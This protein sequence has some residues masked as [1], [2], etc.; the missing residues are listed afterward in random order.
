MPTASRYQPSA[1]LMSVILGVVGAIGSTT[2]VQAASFTPLPFGTYAD[3]QDSLG[4]LLQYLQISGDGTTVIGNRSLDLGIN[5]VEAFRWRQAESLQS[6]GGKQN[7]ALGISYDGSTIAGGNNRQ[8]FRWTEPNGI[9][10]L[11]YLPGLSESSIALAVSADGLTI[12]GNS[13]G[14]FSGPRSGQA[15]RWTPS[16]GMQGLGYLTNSTALPGFT[17]F[18]SSRANDVSGNGSVIV[19]TSNF[20]GSYDEAFRWTAAGGMQGL[21]FLPGG[22]SSFGNAVSQDGQTIVGSGSVGSGFP[23]INA[24]AFRWTATNG[25]Q[26]LDNLGYFGG[27]IAVRIGF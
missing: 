8:A 22:N 25:I 20:Y 1:L 21:G 16:N 13:S 14:A 19:G 11:G 27:G 17:D 24:K 26:D 3:A 2:Q 23:V 5:T 6:L 15:F 12:V 18:T 7:L 4:Y 9:Q 10:N